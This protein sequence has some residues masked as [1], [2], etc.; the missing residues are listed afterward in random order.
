MNF[1]KLIFIFLLI[2]L[3]SYSDNIPERK[4]VAF[5]SFDEGEGIVNDYSGEGNHLTIYGKVKKTKGI[6]GNGI[7]LEGNGYLFCKESNKIG[8]G[9]SGDYSIEFWTKHTSKDSQIYI[10]KWT[11]SGEESAWWIGYYEGVIQFGNYIENKRTI[12]KGIDIADGQWHYI[13]AVRDGED[14]LLYVD[15]QL[16]AKGKCEKGLVGN[17]FADIKIGCYGEGIR[18]GWPF[19]GIIDE[20]KIYL[21][22]LKEDEIKEKYNLAKEGRN[23]PTLKTVNVDNESIPI[24]FILKENEFSTV[25]SK[26]ENIE[27]SYFLISSEILKKEEKK[28]PIFLLK[29][30]ENI[31]EKK[32][33]EI[34]LNVGDKRKEIKISFSPTKPGDYTV[35]GYLDG[36][37]FI[38][39]KI[40]VEDIDKV[41]QENIKIKKERMQKL[42]FE[43]MVVLYGGMEFN[44]NGEPEIEKIIMRVKNLGIKWYGYV[45]QV[46]SEKVLKALPEFCRRGE[47]EGINVIVYLVPPSEA[48]INRY[49]PISER[50]YPPYDMDY[51][52][53]VEEISK[54]STE[55]KNLKILMID[56]FDANLNFFTLDYTK[57]I[58]EKI[59]SINPDLKFGVCVYYEHLENFVK[60]G[61][62]PYFDVILWGY[63]HSFRLTPDCGVSSNS[64]H[65]EINQYYKLCPDKIIIPCIYLTPHPSWI[66]NRPTER[67]LKDAFKISYEEAGALWIFTKLYISPSSPSWIEDWKYKVIEEFIKSILQKGG[68]K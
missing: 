18:M 38:K 68:T 58:Y 22:P 37:L 10:S 66:E 65:L 29:E 60:K 21:R 26:N 6:I 61:Y 55:L 2:L 67:Y 11:G 35:E 13:V 63:Q 16:M 15:G 23:L 56:D 1:K 34:N 3:F 33:K 27:L 28:N 46:N 47:K 62:L 44:Q 20:I 59:K 32:E 45:I 14:L 54:I 53:W 30:G 9:F 25:Y 57:K 51:V 64:L 52:K 41:K 40:K 8:L 39:R 4:L 7:L 42:S 5:W 19:K 50:K 49:K 24:V 48:P 17:N 12:I 43:E 31:I 36:T